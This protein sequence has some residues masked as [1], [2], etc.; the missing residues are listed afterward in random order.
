MAEVLDS[1][2]GVLGAA[3]EHGVRALGRSERQ[4]VEG[5]AFAASGEDAGAGGLGEPEGAHC[6]HWKA[7]VRAG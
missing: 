1:L 7:R 2:A 5:N 3:Q 6:T 4:L